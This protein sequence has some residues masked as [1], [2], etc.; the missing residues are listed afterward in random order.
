MTKNNS[1]MDKFEKRRRNTKFINYFLT[2]AA[3]LVL[4]LI[5]AWIFGG[6]DKKASDDNEGSTSEEDSFFLETE[7]ENEKPDDEEANGKEDSDDSEVDEDDRNKDEEDESVDENESEENDDYDEIETV[8][9]EPSDDDVAEAVMGNW[10]P[11]GTEQTGP[12]TT[13]YEDGS[14]DRI[15]IK[16]AASK[17]TGIPEDDLIEVWIGNGGDQKVVATVSNRAQTEKYRIFMS[18]IDEEGWQP[19]KLETLK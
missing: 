9:T 14:A 2:I 1:R 7:D 4:F 8:E 12:H 5:G 11:I 6:N 19:T 18:W 16:R 10:P 3:V 13:N 15:E 17:V